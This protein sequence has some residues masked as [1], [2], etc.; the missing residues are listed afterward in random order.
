MVNTARVMGSNHKADQFDIPLH[1][2][3][4]SLTDIPDSE[5]SQPKSFGILVMLLIQ[6]VRLLFGK[7]KR[8]L[9]TI[10]LKIMYLLLSRALRAVGTS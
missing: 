10:V 7:R 8:L 2:R 9:V 1:N 4:Q 5:D 3:F 6:F